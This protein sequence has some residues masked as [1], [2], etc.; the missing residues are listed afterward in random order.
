MV[1]AWNIK[2]PTGKA[3]VRNVLTLAGGIAMGAFSK[4]FSKLIIGD[5]TGKV[6]LMSVNDADLEG[7]PIAMKV[8]KN[9]NAEIAKR[10]RN[11][12]SRPSG[13]SSAGKITLRGVPLQHAL[14]PKN[15]RRPKL[16]I[17]HAEPPPPL[18]REA[19]QVKQETSMD[20]AQH[21]LHE[22]ILEQHPGRGVYQ[23]PNYAE[24]PSIDETPWYRFEAHEEND[25]S[26]SLLPE[27]RAQQQ[28]MT[29]QKNTEL[30]LE[31]LPRVKSSDPKKH[32]ENTKLDLDFSQLSLELRKVLQDDKVEIEED[33]TDSLK[34][35]FLP[36]SKI[37]RSGKKK[38][39]SEASRGEAQER[40]ME[41]AEVTM[42]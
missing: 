17:P 16:I 14:L 22:G 4:D 42:A 7:G 19:T 10:T 12:T 33:F 3:F 27:F 13:V 18:G 11:G 34:F 6:Y 26:K 1:K 5:A 40:C 35:D 41:N 38:S 2:A 20:I 39:K 29:R 21:Y 31:R 28:Y 23:G 24:G 9:S 37:F 25:A 32:E 15:I 36:R 30:R 8:G